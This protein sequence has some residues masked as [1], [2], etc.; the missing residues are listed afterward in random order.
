MNGNRRVSCTYRVKTKKKWTE[1]SLTTRSQRMYLLDSKNNEIDSVLLH[2]IDKE[3]E[4]ITM[5]HHEVIYDTVCDSIQE[6]NRPEESGKYVPRQDGKIRDGST[7]HNPNN[8]NSEDQKISIPSE[9]DKKNNEN[10]S[11]LSMTKTVCELLKMFKQHQN[12]SH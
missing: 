3:E 1:G 11:K 12:N 5:E 8:P 7:A 10:P 6:I 2:R 9:I 4:T